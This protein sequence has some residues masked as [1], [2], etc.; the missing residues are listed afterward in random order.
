MLQLLPE[1]FEQILRLGREQCRVELRSQRFLWRNTYVK[2]V[3]ER[4]AEIEQT[5]KQLQLEQ[6]A[7]RRAESRQKELDKQL[8]TGHEAHKSEEAR[9]KKQLGELRLS[10]E[11]ANTQVEVWSKLFV[12]PP[13]FL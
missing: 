7:R 5:H 6:E 9:L 1:H 10:L 12:E 13:F 2:A 4:E 8:S 3:E 11:A